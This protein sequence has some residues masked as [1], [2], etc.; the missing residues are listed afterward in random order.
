MQKSKRRQEHRST[1]DLCTYA[2]ITCALMLTGCA[3]QQQYEPIEQLCVPNLDKHEAMQIAEDVLA[4][5]CF[6]VEKVDH[7]SGVI[8]TRPL[9]GAQ[10]FEFW[11]ADNV[12]AFNTA[13]ANLHSIRRAVE[14]NIQQED[15]G[16]RITCDVQ[17]Q[18]LSLPER[19][20][21]SSARA[22]RMFSKS[23]SSMQRL[24]L[25]PEQ[26][27]GMAWVDLGN[28]TKLATEILKRIEEQI[29]NSRHKTMS[30]FKCPNGQE[31]SNFKF[32]HLNPSA[33]LRTGLFRISGFD[34]LVSE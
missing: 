20:V 34:I 1:R 10:F 16:L 31:G 9:S 21:S 29:R 23:A 17:V 5:M 19:Q 15:E 11:R 32:C 14:L 24:E 2:L 6:A 18:R 7:E 26:K 22:Y 4:R 25:S 12:G 27:K 13:E 3:R 8:R 30:K 28:D 33:T